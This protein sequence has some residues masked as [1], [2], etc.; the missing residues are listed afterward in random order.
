M[1]RTRVLP[2]GLATVLAVSTLAG[3][4]AKETAAP[5][6]TAKATVVA[7]TEA[8]KTEAAKAEAPTEN[9]ADEKITIHCAY[10]LAESDTA[11]IEDFNYAVAKF[12][13]IYPNIEVI[14]DVQATNKSDDYASKY[15]MLLLAGDQTDI[16]WTSGAASYLTRA[17]KGVFA[18]L[19][20]YMAEYGV[21]TDDW[22]VPITADDGKTYGFPLGSSANVVLLNVDALEEA[23][24]AL[25]E[26]TWTWDD[27]AEY[28]KKLTKEVDGKKRYGSIAPFWAD[29][30]MYYLAVQQCK[31]GNPLYIDENTHNF[32]DPVLK[33]WLEFK[34]QM[35]NVDK[36][37]VSY[38]DYTTGSLNYQSEFFSGNAAMLVTGLFS[39]GN[40]DNLESY[41]H[42][43]KTA[44]AILPTWKDNKPGVERDDTNFLSVNAN[45]DEANK[46]AAFKFIEYFA[47][48]GII[49][50]GKAPSH[51]DSEYSVY[52]DELTKER[53]EMYDLDSINRYF[54]SE[55]RSAHSCNM[56][57]ATNGEMLNILKEEADL[58]MSDA[59]TI[60][61]AIEKMI[62]RA[63]FVLAQ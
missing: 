40:A 26:E 27:Y 34:Y 52:I 4:G 19:D 6:T 1:K 28:A 58:Y 33:E 9:A 7:K 46:E 57:P 2:V 51:K 21:S 55:I 49:Y 53:P 25:P 35:E 62:S 50:G 11:A 13:E 30:V 20:E 37:E 15:D 36:S 31:E 24:L 5:E 16:I 22:R 12:N 45:I 3:C 42:D 17:Q 41:P 48:E 14:L 61:E 44:I 39:L 43:F 63:E 32:N 8:V 56:V 60:D 18:S 29:P 59:Q 54:Y 38:V 47:R 23:G 10:P